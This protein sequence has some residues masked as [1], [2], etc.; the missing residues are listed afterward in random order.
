[1]RK[2]IV[3]AVALAIL[4]GLAPSISRADHCT[5]VSVFSQPVSVVE[6]N[7][8]LCIVDGTEDTEARIFVPGSTGFYLRYTQDLGAEV[9][10]VYAD[11]SGSLFPNG[12]PNG[13][14]IK[15]T[16]TDPNGLGTFVYDSATVTFPGG[17]TAMGCVT[18][19]VDVEDDDLATTTYRTVGATC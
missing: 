6:H 3:V 13:K 5:H 16:R 14:R 17:R 19:T 11:V 18:I 4:T 12:N 15:L 9:P 8:A 1:M 7:A 2:H 10:F